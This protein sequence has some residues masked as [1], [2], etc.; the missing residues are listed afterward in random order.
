[1]EKKPPRARPGR[2]KPGKFLLRLPTSLHQELRREAGRE[3]MSLNTLCVAKLSR[4]L[5]EPNGGK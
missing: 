1:M 2:G 3:G 4:P 5:A